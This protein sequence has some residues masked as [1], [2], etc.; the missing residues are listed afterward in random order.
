MHICSSIYIIFL[1][2][3]MSVICL[4]SLTCLFI[5][6]CV[7][8]CKEVCVTLQV[9]YRTHIIAFVLFIVFGFIHHYQ[10][11]AYSMPGRPLVQSHAPRKSSLLSM[12]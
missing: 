6:S 11:W 12:L 2:H 4:S 5:P 3:R 1:L 10:L 7:K 8:S 9:F